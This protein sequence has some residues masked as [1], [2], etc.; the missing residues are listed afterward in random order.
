MS[1]SL[2]EIYYNYIETKRE[3]IEDKIEKKYKLKKYIEQYKPFIILFF[4]IA[5]IFIIIIIDGYDTCKK[6]QHNTINSECTTIKGGSRGIYLNAN[7]LHSGGPEPEYLTIGE[8]NGSNSPKGSN[9]NKPDYLSIYSANGSNSPKGSNYSGPDN[10][11]IGSASGSNSPS[12]AGYFNPRPRNN[13]NGRYSRSKIVTNANGYADPNMLR[14]ENPEIFE[15]VPPAMPNPSTATSS[16]TSTSSNT[17]TSSVT[18]NSKSKDGDTDKKNV[19]QKNTNL[20]TYEKVMLRK[21][22]KKEE[23]K[24]KQLKK[25][26]KRKPNKEIEGYKTRKK[27]Q[28]TLRGRYNYS[29]M[30]RGNILY[31]R[32]ERIIVPKLEPIM[33]KNFAALFFYQLYKIYNAIPTFFTFVHYESMWKNM[34]YLLIKIL[35]I[36]IFI[37]IMFMII[38][39]LPALLYLVVLY[40]L[41]KGL[42]FK[43]IKL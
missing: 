39:Y 15:T 37:I 7:D 31:L 34:I 9:Y 20:S 41:I 13:A 11:S 4:I 43:L 6:C 18:S 35:L 21:A 28:S 5:F 32:L 38:I 16:T 27:Q 25:E 17:A 42:L 23:K 8:A 12:D 40:G 1:L 14:P 22:E 29:A 3:E 30:A 33:G 24:Q 36:T 26:L 10:L 19:K 2:F